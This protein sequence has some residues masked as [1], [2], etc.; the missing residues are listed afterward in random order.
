M[1]S[2]L[3]RAA[4]VVLVGLVA[5]CAAPKEQVVLLPNPAGLATAVTVS[6]G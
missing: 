6:Q 5:A 4:G 2:W 3:R 1:S